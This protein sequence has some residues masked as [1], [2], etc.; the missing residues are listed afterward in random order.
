MLPA[1]RES[2]LF[3]GSERAALALTEAIT[4]LADHPD[5]VSDEIWARAAEHFDESA[6]AALGGD[7]RRGCAALVRRMSQWQIT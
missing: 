1:W 2:A 7:A 4:R 5:A 3:S 6:L